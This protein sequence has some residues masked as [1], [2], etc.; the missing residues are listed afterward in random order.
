MELSLVTYWNKL[1][2]KLLLIFLVLLASCDLT[3]SFNFSSDY[4][5]SPIAV[6]CEKPQ[7]V[8]LTFKREGMPTIH[9]DEKFVEFKQIQD[10][11]GN[12][13]NVCIFQNLNLL[14]FCQYKGADEVAPYWISSYQKINAVKC[15][16]I[17]K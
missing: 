12:I 9:I 2:N 8:S 10:D 17:L 1:M 4:R 6:D 16:E 15:K 11:K 5:N 14:Q 7:D 3:N 13:R